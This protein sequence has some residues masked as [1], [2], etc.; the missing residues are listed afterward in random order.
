MRYVM[1]IPVAIL[2]SL[3]VFCA[4]DSKALE[5]TRK[6]YS[7]MID[8]VRKYSE[9]INESKDA[10]SASKSILSFIDS[11]NRLLEKGKILSS[12]YP[13]IRNDPE[14]VEYERSLEFAMSDFSG[15][16]KTA[17][18]RYKNAKVFRNAV[19]ALKNRKN[20]KSNN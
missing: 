1:I 9:E 13:D 6:Y 3:N 7:E 12:K 18:S 15:S 20:E 8:L 10:D 5:E 4:K 11:R 14:L 2:M 17:I 19:E 16:L